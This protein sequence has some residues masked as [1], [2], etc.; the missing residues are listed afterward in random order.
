MADSIAIT[1]GTGANVG[2][3][4]VTMP[5]ST[6]ADL[7]VIKAA[8]G[9]NTELTG[10]LGGRADANSEGIAYVDPR[11]L[12]VSPSVTPTISTSAYATGYA[13]GPQLSFT[14]AARTAGGSLTV[15]KATLSDASDQSAGIDLVLF[16]AQP[17]TSTDHT[18]YSLSSTDITKVAGVIPF[19]Q[20]YTSYG[21]TSVAVVSKLDLPILLTSGTTLYGQLV[22]WGTP[23]YAST[24]AISVRLTIRQD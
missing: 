19:A 10:Y 21:S 2:I 1:P 9:K 12:I 6:S 13:L 14:S 20:S 24:S 17:A 15:L 4:P 5:D 8:L 3:D 23:T 22:V 7:Q 16:N 11:R 18:A